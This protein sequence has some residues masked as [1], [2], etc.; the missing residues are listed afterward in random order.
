MLAALKTSIL[1]VETRILQILGTQ[2]PS[3]RMSN[4]VIFQSTWI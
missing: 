1:R 2:Y 3:G 4:I